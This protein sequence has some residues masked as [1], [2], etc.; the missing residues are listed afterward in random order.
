MSTWEPVRGGARGRGIARACFLSRRVQ[1]IVPLLWIGWVACMTPGCVMWRPQWP[2]RSAGTR[3]GEAASRLE[4]AS[5]LGLQAD[6]RESIERAVAAYQ[7]VLE[8]DPDS[9]EAYVQLAQF[10]LLLGDGYM[11]SV[12]DKKSSFR[13]AML[14][15]EGAMYTQPA[16][17]QKIQEGEP[18][19]DACRVLGAREMDAMFFWVNSVFYN[20]KECYGYM[21]QALNFRWIQRAKR[22]MEHMDTID[23]GWGNGMLYFTWGIYYLS[24]PERVG[25][26]RPKSEMY[27]SKAIAADPRQLVYRWGRAKYYDIKMNKPQEFQED[28]EWVLAQDARLSPGH[29]AWNAFIMQDARRLLESMHSRF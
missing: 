18:T 22:V 13:S 3:G 25:G 21:G 12:A 27:L 4:Q 17:R 2:D 15:A 23:P 9:Y 16:F 5:R 10:H 29:P 8:V 26:D 1:R 24:I 6:S 28:L 19:W 7:A 11:A 20:F 14:Y